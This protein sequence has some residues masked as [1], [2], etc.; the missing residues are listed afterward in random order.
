M[1]KSFLKFTKFLSCAGF[2][3]ACTWAQA[4]LQTAVVGEVTLVVGSVQLTSAQGQ[5]QGFG[6]GQAVREG[7]Q[8]ETGPGGHV[9]LRFVDGGRLSVR[10]SSRLSIQNY[11][12]GELASGKTAIRFKLD[13]GVV[14][15]I[16]GQWGQA[17][18]ERFRLN[19]PLAAIG[20]KGTD[21]TAA[22]DATQ[23]VASV[24]TGAIVMAPIDPTCS[25][26][27]GPCLNGS[28]RLLSDRM[29]G[30]MLAMADS[31]RE[32]VLVALASLKPL[33]DGVPQGQTER[34]LGDYHSEKRLVAETRPID[35]LPPADGTAHQ[36]TWM[37]W[38]WTH[39]NPGDAFTVAFDSAVLRSQER[40]VADF[41]YVLLRDSAP[42]A[43]LLMREGHVDFKLSGATAQL[44]RTNGMQ[45][46]RD[47][48]GV[49]N[50]RLSV[51]FSRSTYATSLDVVGDR[52]GQLTLSSN[53]QILP[54]GAMQSSQGTMSTKGVLSTN[55]LEAGYFFFSNQPAGQVRGITLWGH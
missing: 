24:Y 27:L 31:A 15:S 4:S 23:T 46:T 5:V 20:I 21:F 16:T 36:L 55:G 9:H 45:E 7:D 17:E 30:Q 32:P 11:S 40:S 12:H 8:I 14:R 6:R 42:N 19:T 3:F 1:T 25:N 51:D 28:E 35:F 38:P 13:Q 49:A 10:P 34:S 2:M 39:E 22:A 26:T 43:P 37:R 29:T 18:R 44:V 54:T 53:G 50:G 52:L 33:N 41:R 47:P 48:L